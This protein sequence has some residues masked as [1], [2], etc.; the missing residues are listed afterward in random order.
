MPEK[1]NTEV[2]I[3]GLAARRTL[4]ALVVL[5][6]SVAGFFAM[7]RVVADLALGWQMATLALF[8]LTFGWIAMAFWGAVCGFVLCALRLD[9][10]TL[11]RQ[12]PA[13]PNAYQL[14]SKTAL[15]MPIY[16][17]P[18]V[19]TIAGL[20]AT[21]RSLL[22]QADA[23]SMAGAI[24]IHHHFDVFILSDTQEAA[25]AD[26]EAAHVAALQQRL[27]GQINVYYR[28]REE[29]QGR[30]AGNIAEFC[31]RWGR[32]YDY[33][34]VLDADS[35]MSGA[36]L[37]HMVHRMQRE[38]DVGLIQTVPIPVGQRTL[39]GRFTQLASALYSPMLA[40]GQSFWQG[41]AANYWGHNAIIRVRAFM[42]HAGLPAL[43]GKAPLG[44]EVLSHDFVEAA[45]LKRGGW[46]VLLDTSA[47]TAVSHESPLT[48]ASHNSFEAMPS[49]LLDFA[50]RDR[51][52]LQGN[53]QHLRLL[54]GAGFHPISRLHF[55]FG[56]FAYLSSV[57]WLGLLVC[58][59]LLIGV[60]AMGSATGAPLPQPL[61]TGLLSVTL[62][63]LV[64]PKLLGLLLTLGQCPRAF[65]GRFKLTVSVVLELVFAA[66]IA[67]LMMAWHTLFIVNVLLGRSIE[68]QTQHRGER[69]LTWNETWWHTGWMTIC[70]VAWAGALYL[71]SPSAFAWL[72]PAW[73]GLVAAAPIV[74]YSSS[75][76]W[77][78][79]LAYRL[80]LLKTPSIAFKPAL[81]RDFAALGARSDEPGA[82]RAPLEGSA[83]P[84]PLEL[85]GDMP[86]QS[87][88]QFDRRPSIDSAKEPH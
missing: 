68:W 23:H 15:V 19:P 22:K 72:S 37:L 82:V 33:M 40:A 52:W 77:G 46:K 76:T 79:V 6:S 61:S 16:A 54:S 57:V 62:F 73:F 43:P 32:R 80:G 71:L 38:P 42:A 41:D 85:L 84:L 34:V 51:R 28:R 50:K 59:S 36:T 24:N 27:A 2:R 87:F 31:R 14:V 11:R 69:S 70:G 12:R 39:F 65:G 8:V 30:K 47:T 81:L 4:F 18:P 78:G 60:Q 1:I 58:T 17:E 48:G 20:E 13:S 83:T 49:N 3:P 55:L 21:C 66:L 45:L 7:L 5:A 74:K 26:E 44:G 88:R 25:Q 53:L 75:G 63:M 10:L 56:A 35:L 29:N 67:P 86:C 64:A 9:P